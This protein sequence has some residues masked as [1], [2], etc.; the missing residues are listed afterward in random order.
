DTAI[1]R[2]R[3]RMRQDV[4]DQIGFDVAQDEVLSDDPVLHL[5]RRQWRE[6]RQERGGKGGQR[7]RRGIQHVHRR[8]EVRQLFLRVL[9]LLDDRVGAATV[10]PLDQLGDKGAGFWSEDVALFGGI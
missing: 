7:V 6:Q 3:N 5:V 10:F 1:L 2:L 4:D 8:H 9:P